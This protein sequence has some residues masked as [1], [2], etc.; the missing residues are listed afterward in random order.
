MQCVASSVCSA[1]PVA[2]TAQRRAAGPLARPLTGARP[3]QPA[4]ERRLNAPSRLRKRL[5]APCA[6]IG[7][8]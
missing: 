8:A 2:A 5:R 3:L 4:G 7:L 1:R 6:A